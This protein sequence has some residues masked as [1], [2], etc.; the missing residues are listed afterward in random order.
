MFN[1]V[2]ERIPFKFIFGIYKPA[3]THLYIFILI[4]TAHY[5]KT[6]LLYQILTFEDIST[7]IT[8]TS[9]HFIHFA[10]CRSLSALL[11]A[12][13]TWASICWTILS[14]Y[15]GVPGTHRE[16][17]VSPQV[18]QCL[19][20][21]TH[22]HTQSLHISFGRVFLVYSCRFSTAYHRLTLTLI[23]VFSSLANNH[24]TF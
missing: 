23:L 4:L 24:M 7:F 22:T 11:H 9:L 14:A 1:W 10:L 6:E 20:T 12:G 17:L 8:P 15:A 13:E 18:E 16:N 5:F 19:C 21:Q 2:C 3:H